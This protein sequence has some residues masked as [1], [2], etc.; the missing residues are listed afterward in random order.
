MEWREGKP[1]FGRGEREREKEG[2]DV[3]GA[4]AMRWLRRDMFGDILYWQC[5]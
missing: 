1:V 2:E 5:S 4:A 3:L